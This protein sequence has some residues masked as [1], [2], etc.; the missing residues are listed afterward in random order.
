V[1]SIRRRIGGATIL[2]MVAWFGRETVVW[3]FNRL[4]D[5]FASNEG[6]ATLA[7]VPWQNVVATLLGLFGLTMVLWPSKRVVKVSPYSALWQRGQNVVARIRQQRNRGAWL[8][9]MNGEPLTDVTRDGISTL[10]LFAEQGLATPQFS[11]NRAEKIAIGLEAYFSAMIPLLRDGHIERALVYA[12]DASERAQREAV[13]FNLQN[14]TDD[15]Y[16]GF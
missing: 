16:A 5:F 14:W 4:L 2:A 11:T 12:P 13:S 9:V 8:R 3:A 6:G 7:A 10:Y 1:G 15:P